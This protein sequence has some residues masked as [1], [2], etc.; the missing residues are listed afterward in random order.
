MKSVSP[1]P[2]LRCYTS[3]DRVVRSDS[4]LSRRTAAVRAPRASDP[5]PPDWRWSS[6]W[7]SS[8]LSRWTRSDTPAGSRRWSPRSA[9]SQAP[10][11]AGYVPPPPAP[12]PPRSGWPPSPP[13]LLRS[14]PVRAT[15]ARPPDLHEGRAGLW[16]PLCGLLMVSGRLESDS[17]R[18]WCAAPQRSDAHFTQRF[19]VKQNGSRGNWVSF[20]QWNTNTSLHR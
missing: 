5:P 1:V 3:A 18:L 12:Q 14:V 7:W 11:R 10:E 16:S 17:T 8:A 4:P 15:A 20:T 19:R 6:W 2:E 13:R 9:A